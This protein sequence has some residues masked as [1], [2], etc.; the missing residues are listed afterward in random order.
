MKRPGQSIDTITY[1][2]WTYTSWN[3]RTATRVCLWS[4]NVMICVICKRQGA[5]NLTCHFEDNDTWQLQYSQALQT[6]LDTK[7][8][9]FKR[10]SSLDNWSVEW[11]HVDNDNLVVVLTQSF[12]HLKKLALSDTIYKPPVLRNFCLRLE[13]NLF[14]QKMSLSETWHTQTIVQTNSASVVEP[15]EKRREAF[16]NS[17]IAEADN[18]LQGIQRDM[19]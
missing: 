3:S 6:W 12:S 17:P 2:K 7:L 10:W 15:A 8:K 19:K 16:S 13:L 18:T 4:I 1:K 9:A 14:P 5:N 11:L